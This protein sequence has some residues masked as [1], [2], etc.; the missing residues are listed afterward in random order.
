MV[1]F[2]FHIKVA[3]RKLRKGEGGKYVNKEVLRGLGL[4]EHTAN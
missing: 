2:A 4:S 3:F 1:V